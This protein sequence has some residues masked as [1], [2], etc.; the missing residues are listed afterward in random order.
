MTIKSTI[1]GRKRAVW[2]S[3]FHKRSSWEETDRFP[4]TLCTWVRAGWLCE[5]FWMNICV[6]MMWRVAVV[7]TSASVLCEHFFLLMHDSWKISYGYIIPDWF[8]QCW[9]LDAVCVWLSKVKVS[10]P[11]VC[12]WL[13][14]GPHWLWDPH[15]GRPATQLKHCPKTS[16][17]TPTHLWA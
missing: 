2:S 16:L 5:T 7:H 15:N 14:L 8:Y 10:S 11:D 4:Y 3:L 9:T 1:W 17:L 13:S 12:N 6:H